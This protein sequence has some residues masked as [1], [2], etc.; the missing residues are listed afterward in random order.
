M[1]SISSPGIGSGL[2][3]NSI[4]SQLVAAEG[5]PVKN[6]LD[7][8]ETELQTR[9]S[10]YGAL[11]GAVSGFQSALGKL[12]SGS[13]FQANST[14]SSNQ[15]V[16]VATASRTAVP[17]S[18]DMNVG[19]LARAHSLV[20]DSSLAGGQFESTSDVL[21]TGTLTFKFGTTVAD[22]VS[23]TSFTPNADAAITT[24]EITDGSL[25]GI[26]DAINQAN[27]GVRAAVIHD[28]S[29]FRLTLTSTDTG[30]ERS[31]EISVSDADGNHGDAV[32]LS[33]LSFNAGAA[34]MTQTSAG[35]D[36]QLTLN[37][38]AITS[39][40]NTLSSTLTGLT[41][42]LLGEGSSTLKVEQNR[43]EATASIRGFVDSYNSLMGGINQLTGYDP[44]TRRAGALNGDSSVQGLKNQLSRMLSTPVEGLDG[45][46]SILA[47]IGISRNSLDGTLVL[48]E[49]K[50]QTSLRENYDSVMGLF[51]AAGR[52]SDAQVQ[53]LGHNKSTQ[54]GQ[55]AV[56]ITR[57]ASQGSLTGSVAANLDITAGVNDTL[58]IK[59]D[60]VEASIT[61]SAGTYTAASLAA[62]LQS[63]ING[64]KAFADLGSGVRVSEAGGVLSLRSDRYG[65]ASKVEVTG[66]NGATALLGGSPVASTGEDVAGTIG[67]Q[68]ATGSGQ[69]LTGTGS[70]EGLRLLISGGTTGDRGEIAF[71]RGFADQMNDLVRGLLADDGLFK[72]MSASL[73]ERLAGIATEREKLAARLERFEQRISAQFTAMDQLVNQLQNT[74]NYLTQQLE[75]LP[76]IGANNNNRR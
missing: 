68:R 33:L 28:G 41:I 48:D 53:V 13:G 55:Y 24:V 7:R 59:L 12:V 67:G 4:V 57:M 50:L 15:D 5:Q 35:Q 1:A 18:Y 8:T 40:S 27:M 30:A 9:I 75:A 47:D 11:Q 42:N 39:A 62:E 31:M 45:P 70:A 66:G 60:G 14:S 6:R 37:G 10:A 63:R 69:N 74:G 17:G 61:L 26:R 56:N 54:V 51:A 25:N 58:K 34:N 72:N 46:F 2:D 65:S 3:I 44:E 73:D 29:H 49:T 19:Q 23:Y 52:S 20:T 64:T 43:S 38:L 22:A 32:G 36:A 71:S 21:G 76:V 16:L